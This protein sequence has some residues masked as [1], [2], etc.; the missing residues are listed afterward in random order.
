MSKNNGWDVSRRGLFRAGAGAV[1]AATAAGAS[2]PSYAQE[3][4]DYDGWF[5]DVGN[6]EGTVDLTGEGEV[7]VDVGAGDLGLEFD[8]PAI[9]VDPGTTIIFEWTGEGGGHNVV[10][11]ETGERYESERTDEGGTT[12]E[13]TVESDGI[14]KYVCVP[15]I[16]NGMKGAIAV[17]D[18]EGVPEI[19]EGETVIGDPGGEAEDETDADEDD[20]DAE[21]EVPPALEPGS[22]V[23]ALFGFS[24]IIALLSPLIVLVLMGR[25]QDDEG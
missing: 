22:G 10:E 15:H 4:F 25:R 7:S 20:N 16:E 6:F 24:A 23:F 3:T 5:D 2:T 13:L 8:P 14:S 17:G 11:R 1:T 9:H 12:Y 18:G 21:E 19:S